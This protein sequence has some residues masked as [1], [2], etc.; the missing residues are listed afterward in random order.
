MAWVFH[1][2]AYFQCFH[3]V[4]YS[5]RLEKALKNI[6]GKT[7]Y[8]NSLLFC[9]ESSGC[10]EHTDQCITGNWLN[11]TNHFDNLIGSKE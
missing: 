3:R 2:L 7:I 8:D 6:N 1:M 4:I 9:C 10:T 11:Q 5:F